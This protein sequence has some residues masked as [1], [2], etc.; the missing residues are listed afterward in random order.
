MLVPVDGLVLSVDAL[1]VLA[2]GLVK[3]LAELMLVACEVGEAEF[4]VVNPEDVTVEN[5]VVIKEAELVA[6][7]PV[8][9]IPI[10]VDV[11]TLAE[12]VAVLVTKFVVVTEVDVIDVVNVVAVDPFKESYLLQ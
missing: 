5:V 3:G 4:N 2:E 10:G 12:V 6:V 11:V 9:V 7:N 1:E 8:V